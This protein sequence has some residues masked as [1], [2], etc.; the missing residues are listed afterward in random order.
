VR[1]SSFTTTTFAYSPH[2]LFEEVF[3]QTAPAAL[4]GKPVWET[5]KGIFNYVAEDILNDRFARLF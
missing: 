5:L 3:G 4:V 2:F 1:G